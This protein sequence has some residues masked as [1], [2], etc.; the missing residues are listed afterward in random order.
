MKEKLLVGFAIFIMVFG[1]I[2]FNYVLITENKKAEFW[3][4]V[5]MSINL[6]RK[7]YIHAEAKINDIDPDLIRA[8]IWIESQGES[9]AISETGCRGISQINRGNAI[10]FGYKHD[11]MHDDKKALQVMARLLKESR[12]YYYS[13]NKLKKQESLITWMLREYNVGREVARK[14]F[15]AAKSYAVLVNSVYEAIKKGT[16]QIVK[17]GKPHK[18]DIAKINGEA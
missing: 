15:L 2:S 13:N 8:I 7:N 10:H 18:I 4:W 12:D 17:N 3:R 9:K 5:K 16:F 1:F 14:N 6:E 11:E